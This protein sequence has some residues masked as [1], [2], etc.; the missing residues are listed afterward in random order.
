MCMFCLGARGL[1]WT[2]EG[3]N[4]GEN[5]GHGMEDF[6]MHRGEN[7]LDAGPSGLSSLAELDEITMTT[8]FGKHQW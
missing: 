3:L 2:G 4:T 6:E 1:K 8:R 7:L 5:F